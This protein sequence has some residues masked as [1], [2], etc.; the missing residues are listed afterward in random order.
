MEN[1]EFGD[2]SLV[3]ATYRVLEKFRTENKVYAKITYPD[4]KEQS[5]YDYIA[6]REAVINAIVHNDWSTEY[7]PKFEFFSDRLEISS[8]GG[9]QSE[10]TEEEF[11]LGYSAP[12]NPELMRVFRDLELVEHLGTG[13]RR[14][15][16]RYD[17]SIYHFYPHFIRVSIKYNQN[18][19]KYNNKQ[20]TNDNKLDYSNSELNNIQRGIIGLMFD[21]P[22]ITQD[23]MSNLLG[24]TPRTI[25]NHIKYLIDNDYIERTG[26]N[27]NGKWIVKK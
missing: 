16:K 15:L 24:V 21:S 27:K 8:F 2:C 7:P 17:K 12:K 18:E 14:I 26:A 5:M 11:L 23:E 9:I 6:V 4:R 20:K 1:Y 19:F 3:K 22:K 13:I 25:R 10:F